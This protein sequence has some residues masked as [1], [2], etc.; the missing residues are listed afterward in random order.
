MSDTNKLPQA[1]TIITAKL[2]CNYPTLFQPRLPPDPKPGAKARY[3]I[4]LMFENDAEGLAEAKR[5]KMAAVNCAIAALDGNKERVAALFKD[6]KLNLGIRT[7]GQTR[8]TPLPS[9]YTTYFQPWGYQQPGV[10]DSVADPSTGKA[11]KITNPSDVF[12]GCFVRASVAP[13]FYDVNG[14]KG[15]GW[16]LRNVQKLAKG[17]RLDNR[18]DAED[19]FEA[20]ESASALLPEEETPSALATAAS[21]GVTSRNDLESLLG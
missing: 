18:R 12:S 15:V 4:T 10:V 17:E 3:S 20:T 2:R 6:G 8:D 11:R 13:W 7:D 1:E 16:G 19:E 21:T 5:M 9:G 14:N